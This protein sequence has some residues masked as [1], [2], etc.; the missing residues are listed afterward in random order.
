MCFA[1]LLHPMS[2]E[3][4]LAVA[5]SRPQATWEAP[6]GVRAAFLF[7]PGVV[8]AAVGASGLA[9]RFIPI[10]H[11]LIHSRGGWH[12]CTGVGRAG[13][14]AGGN[15]GREARQTDGQRFSSRWFTMIFDTRPYS[16]ASSADIQ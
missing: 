5:L 2:P 12:R 15:A 13:K 4:F 14:T 6:R 9:H 8:P 16:T 11:R 7:W 10:M 3:D 1:L